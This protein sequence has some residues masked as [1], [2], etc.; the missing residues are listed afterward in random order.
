MYDFAA[1]NATD[2]KFERTLVLIKP[3]SIHR[4]L[5]GQIID[6]F[7][8]RGLKLVALKFIWVNIF[9]YKYITNF[10]ITLRQ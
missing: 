5:I 1:I 10:I 4:G 2:G 6:R 9:L 7:E 3:E 8:K